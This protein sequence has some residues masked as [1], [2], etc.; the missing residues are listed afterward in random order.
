M[1][2]ETRLNKV[3]LR[4]A[5]DSSELAGLTALLDGE[6]PEEIRGILASLKRNGMTVAD[7]VADVEE[8]IAE[9]DSRPEPTTPYDAEYSKRFA[10]YQASHIPIEGF[11]P[12]NEGWG[13]QERH[14]EQFRNGAV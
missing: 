12:D 14:A 10:G 5:D 9:I 3:E 6:S 11:L 4:F 8:V 13:D 1:S 2:L 7:W